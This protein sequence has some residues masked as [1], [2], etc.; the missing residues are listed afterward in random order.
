M[1]IYLERIEGPCAVGR[2]E[3]G[4]KVTLELAALPKGVQ[5][6]HV[7]DVTNGVITIDEA[8]TAARRE[9]V[10]QMLDE[11]VQEAGRKT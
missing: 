9:C 4:E 10:R 5:G 11:M 3:N 8:A 2:N 6:F 7:L 1:K